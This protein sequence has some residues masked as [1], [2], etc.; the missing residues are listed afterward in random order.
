MESGGRSGRGQA[1]LVKTARGLEPRLVRTGLSDFDYTQILDGLNEGDEV[2]LLS[3][4]EQQA[5]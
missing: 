4:L 2:V 3:V 1:V 5:K